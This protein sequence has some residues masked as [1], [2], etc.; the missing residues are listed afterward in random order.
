MRESMMTSA[1]VS[2]WPEVPQVRVFL[3]NPELWLVLE[4]G[5]SNLGAAS[6]AKSQ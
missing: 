1:F 2:G 5:S 3:G 4:S 6:F